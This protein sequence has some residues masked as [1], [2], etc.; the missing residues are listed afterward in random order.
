MWEAEGGRPCQMCS[1]IQLLDCEHGAWRGG[2]GMKLLVF[3]EDVEGFY[4]AHGD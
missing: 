1:R 3:V 2:S 4:R